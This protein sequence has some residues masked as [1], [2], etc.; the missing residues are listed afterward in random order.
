[1]DIDILVKIRTGSHLYGLN[2]P[3]SDEDFSGV[4]MPKA[5][6]LLGLHPM[7]EVDLS[8]KASSVDRKNTKDDVDEKYTA[9]PKF[10]SQVMNNNPNKLELLFVNEENTLI[11]TPVWDELVENTPKILSQKIWW[12]FSGYAYSQKKKIEVKRER[13]FSLRNAIEFLASSYTHG[14]LS[15]PKYV[16]SEKESSDLNHILKFYKGSKGNTEH[17]HKGMPL[18]TI[19]E[20]IC[21]E[22][23][24]YG[25]RV[26][27]E[28]FKTLGYDIK[29]GYHL[30]RLM[31]EAYDLLRYGTLEY[32]ISGIVYDDIMKIRNAEVPYEQLILIYDR[33]Y[34]LSE[35]AFK[36]T[37]LPKK[38]DWKWADK[39]LINTMKKAILEEKDE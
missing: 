19:F 30:V 26:K 14:E 4:F 1:M 11:G 32:P 37:K 21:A 28:S 22:Y 36:T 12:S 23:D 13:Y 24:R 5:K 16:L 7:S 38:P 33:Y 6:D 39:W 10:L 8:T 9:L 25:W 15:D 27:T 17:F 34:K 3:E 35:D 20:K 29:F 2:T 31:A 18:K